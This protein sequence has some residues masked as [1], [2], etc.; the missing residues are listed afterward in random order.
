MQDSVKDVDLYLSAYDSK[1]Y[2]TV[3]TS[4]DS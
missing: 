3:K 1:L 2:T 4:K